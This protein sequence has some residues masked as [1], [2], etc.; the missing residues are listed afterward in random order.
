MNAKRL[1]KT[2]DSRSCAIEISAYGFITDSSDAS[3]EM[4]VV[5]PIDRLDSI[6]EA[7]KQ[8]QQAIL[9]LGS[10]LK[11]LQQ[12]QLAATQVL[13][14]KLTSL[15]TRPTSAAPVAPG[16][17]GIITSAAINHL[18]PMTEATTL[19]GPRVPSRCPGQVTSNPTPNSDPTP[20]LE[21]MPHAPYRESRPIFLSPPPCMPR[22]RGD[23]RKHPVRF[24]EELDSYFKRMSTP[25]SQYLDAVSESLQGA[26]FDWAAIYQGRW[27][28][29]QDFKDDLLAN[30]W[31]DLEQNKLRHR[32]STNTWIGGRYSMGNHFA[33]FVGLA[34]LLTNPIPETTLVSELMR[35]FPTNLQ[36]LWMLKEPKTIAAAATFLK[37]QEGIEPLRIPHQPIEAA[38]RTLVDED[39]TH[40]PAV[41][42]GGRPNKRFKLNHVQY[43]TGNASLSS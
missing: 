30:Y 12:D 17:S 9:E 15:V 20:N 31:S 42:V 39:T 8:N 4:L 16:P 24:L 6:A 41:P 14:D 18:E 43:Q 2:L 28:T 7:L 5:T 19:T 29:Y 25:Q 38:Q 36:S 34:R 26:A 11:T 3:G 22:F 1:R 27:T 21:P 10:S 40:Q 23:D 37:Q 32:L 33:H 13:V 35:H